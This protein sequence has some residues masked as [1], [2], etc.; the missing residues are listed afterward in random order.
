MVRREAEHRFKRSMPVKATIVAEHELVEICVD[1]LAAQTMIRAQPPP[2]HQR[3]DAVN[4]GKH[5][6][7]RHL[8]DHARIMPVVGQSG[9][10]G[11]AVGQERR[12][13]LY[14]GPHESFER[15]RRIVGDHSEAN[16]PGT[17]IEIFG[18]F[19]SRFGLMSVPFNHLD[20]AYN[21]HFAG[22][23]GL[24]ERIALTKGDLGLIDFHDSFERLAIR[25][26]H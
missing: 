26:D 25:I 23:A 22:I 14:V 7:R 5:D 8:A 9:I 13:G 12:A 6:V 18:V 17:R 19:A 16:A 15:G 11:M 21:E 1:V 10:R 4:P 2:L 20:S 24:E 3:E